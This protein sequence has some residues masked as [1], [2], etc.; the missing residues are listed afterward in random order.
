MT[1]NSNEYS[2]KNHTRQVLENV[3]FHSAN[4]RLN[5]I[6]NK[7]RRR[8]TIPVKRWNELQPVPESALLT[9]RLSTL[10]SVLTASERVLL[11]IMIE[12]DNRYPVI[13]VSQETLADYVGISR[14]HVNKS[15]HALEAKGLIAINY[16]HMNSCIYKISSVFHLKEIRDRLK[17]YLP[18]LNS[19]YITMLVPLMFSVCNYSRFKHRKTTQL[20]K[21]QNVIYNNTTTT[22]SHTRSDTM[23]D[24]AKKT[25]VSIPG[26]IFT[27]QEQ[28][29]IDQYS[30]KTI[31]YA[32]EVFYKAKNI[33][34]PTRFFLGIC[35]KHANGLL[36]DNKKGGGFVSPT[37]Q[38]NKPADVGSRTSSMGK[39]DAIPSYMKPQ[40]QLQEKV[41]YHPVEEYYRS[42]LLRETPKYKRAVAI[43]KYH[44]D[45]PFASHMTRLG[46]PLTCDP[47]ILAAMRERERLCHFQGQKSCPMNTQPSKDCAFAELFNPAEDA[48]NLTQEKQND[49]F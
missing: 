46:L 40:P 11:N 39:T 38:P 31:S 28:D 32:K 4:R 12:C 29:Q 34:N 5:S 23:S 10:S 36:F 25:R 7:V 18:S 47:K 33:N 3:G 20:Y 17:N 13:Y 8:R 27:E 15:L 22:V 9:S 14:Q 19:L 43:L 48:S 42:E 6:G 37:L 41:E 16:R 2:L 24:Q 26:L 1:I 45:N 44:P 21:E 30:D 35:R 49:V